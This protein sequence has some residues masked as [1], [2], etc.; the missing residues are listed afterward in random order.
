MATEGTQKETQKESFLLTIPEAERLYDT[1]V[2]TGLNDAQISVNHEKYGKNKM[3]ES[4]RKSVA[5]MFFAQ[6]KDFLI[7]VLMVAAVISGFLGELSDA[8]L[9]MIIVIIN[10][11]I[12]VIQENKAE[13]SMEALKKL[14][15]PEAKVFRNGAQTVIKAEELVPGDVVFLDAGDYVPADGR[16]IEAASLQIQESALTGESLAVEKN[17]DDIANGKT[18]LG[19]RLNSVYMSSMVTYGRGKF[20]V[21]KTGMQSEIGKIAGMIQGTETMQTPLQKRL[22]ELGKILAIGALVA[23]AVVFIIGLIRGGDPL[24]L[25]LTAVSLAVAAIPEGLPAIVTVVLALGTQKLISKHAIIRKLPAVETLGCASVICSDKTGTL[26][27][28]RMTIKKVYANEG[29]VNAEDIKNDGFTS[30]EKLVVRVGLLCND[31]IIVTEEDGVKEIGDPTE[32]AMVAYAASLGYEKNEIQ[33]QCPRIGEIPFDSSRKLMTTI[34]KF[35]DS[36]LSFT[37]GAPD[38]LLGKCKDY[39][40]GYDVLDLDGT[41]KAKIDEANDAMSDK[42]YRVLGFAFKQYFEEP[43]IEMDELENDMIFAGLTGMIDPPREEVKTSIEECHQAGIKTVMITG[44]HKNTAVAIAKDLHIFTEGNLA[45]SG[46]ELSELSD[47]QLEED[48]DRIAVYARVSPEHK[49]RI[50]DAWQKRGAVVAMTGD[51]VN[52]APALKKAD[53]GCAMGIT[54]TDV[55]KEAAEMILTDDNFSTIVSA[56]KEGRGIY[57]NIKKAVH[58]LLSCNIAEILILFIATLIGWVQPLL[59]VHILW[60]NLITDS[61]PALALGVEKNDDDIMEKKPRNPKESIFANGLGGRI[62]FQGIVLAVISLFVFNYGY[63][64]FGVDEARTMVFAV[65]GLSQ[66]THVLNVRSESKSVFSRKLFTNR[67][68]WGAILISMVLQLS[69]ILI[70]AAHAVFNVTFLNMQEW[71]I[72]IGASLAPLVVVEITKLLQRLFKKDTI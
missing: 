26:T 31:S 24:L 5:A 42:A 23:C 8:A 69:V 37:K 29:I 33:E 40:K 18:P 4:K 16:L 49:V 46:T 71:L 61:L 47:E 11:V 53:I 38:V 41:A 66:L 65:L 70:P 68:L 58:F 3:A 32:I 2:S 35:G 21:T 20:I 54:G 14:T 52:D 25:F 28:N 10:A 9:I 51:G 63:S 34:H 15:I 17:T 30:S 48:I 39:L 56:V 6:F 12:G 45:L 36:Y 50:V 60:I 7:I 1:D 67:Y 59:P 57:D 62:V 64:H 43:P 19:D 22:D 55:S 27:Q 72:I 13:N 44:D